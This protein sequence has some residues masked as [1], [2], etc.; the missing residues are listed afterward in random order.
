[1][2]HTAGR[3]LGQLGRASFLLHHVGSRDELDELSHQACDRHPYLLSHLTGSGII[4]HNYFSFILKSYGYY[5]VGTPKGKLT[6]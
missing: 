5:E 1:M 2:Y 4:I 3:I 6:L